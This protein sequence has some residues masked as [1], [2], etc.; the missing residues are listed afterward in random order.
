MSYPFIIKAESLTLWVEG[1]QYTIPQDDKRFD[2]IIELL[3]KREFIEAGDLA[4]ELQARTTSLLK[5]YINGSDVGTEVEIRNGGLFI[6]GALMEGDLAE[7]ILIMIDRGL[8]SEHYMAFA[9]RLARNPSY[10][11]RRDLFQ[12]VKSQNMPISL[13]GHIMGFKVVRADGWDIYT[14]RTFHHHV[15]AYISMPREQVDDDIRRTCSSG[16]HF[17]GESYISSYGSAHRETDRIMVLAIC[18]SEIV[19][20]PADYASCG[21]GRAHAYSVVG[22]MSREQVETYFENRSRV[23]WDEFEYDEDDE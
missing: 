6:D 11:T 20:F 4:R 10:R 5:I 12:W 23:T 13:T 16:A 17:C 9:A 15:G 18:P 7:E 3:K 2:R 19:C 21:K 1:R 8:P 14:G 22:E